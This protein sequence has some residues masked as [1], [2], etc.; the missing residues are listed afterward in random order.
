MVVLERAFDR[1][2]VLA[3]ASGTPSVVFLSPVDHGS[4]VP[5][6]PGVLAGAAVVLNPSVRA[7]D[8]HFRDTV[9]ALLPDN[10]LP[11][12]GLALLA[13]KQEGGRWSSFGDVLEAEPSGSETF[14]A[15]YEA[16]FYLGGSFDERIVPVDDVVVVPRGSRIR[17][18]Q[19][20]SKLVFDLAGAGRWDTV[21]RAFGAS[22]AVSETSEMS[23]EWTQPGAPWQLRGQASPGLVDGLGVQVGFATAR[24]GR[25]PGGSQWKTARV[26]DA[27]RLGGRK[28]TWS[29]TLRTTFLH[30]VSAAFLKLEDAV[31]VHLTSSRGQALWAL[32]KEGENSGRLAWLRRSRSTPGTVPQHS[33]RSLVGGLVGTF[34]LGVSDGLTQSLSR[35]PDV[36]LGANAIEALVPP[37]EQPLVVTFTPGA[38]GIVESQ[39]VRGL[40]A[41]G[42]WQVT[43]Y[44]ELV[45]GGTYRTG[46]EQSAEY[47]PS[48][49]GVS[50]AGPQP[51]VPREAIEHAIA[52]PMPFVPTSALTQSSLSSGTHARRGSREL[53]DA[54][55]IEQVVLSRVR[56]GLGHAAQVKRRKPAT[57]DPSLTS[58]G[59]LGK[60]EA[61]EGR[62]SSID[63]AE[64]RP[65]QR[66]ALAG[67]E[68]DARLAA[69]FESNELFLVARVT[70]GSEAGPS[71]PAIRNRLA[72]GG[73]TFG[74]EG[75]LIA[76]GDRG[77]KDYWLIV[78]SSP[79]PLR[80]LIDDTAE[81][82]M[83]AHEGARRDLNRLLD[84]QGSKR[85]PDRFLSG[86]WSGALVLDY[87]LGDVSAAEQFPPELKA[88]VGGFRNPSDLRVPYI[89]FDIPRVATSGGGLAI[90]SPAVWAHINYEDPKGDP[91]KKTDDIYGFVVTKFA[92]TI[93][94]S[95][96]TKFDG[97][98]KIG[99][100]RIFGERV[101]GRAD[102]EEGDS[103]TVEL[104]GSVQ[105]RDKGTTY[106]FAYEGSHEFEYA[107][108]SIAATAT[109]QRV[110]FSTVTS[111]TGSSEAEFQL[112][113]G[114]TVE[115]G[116][117]D[118]DWE[119][120]LG[121]FSLDY[122]GLP[123]RFDLSG[124]GTRLRYDLGRFDL[125]VGDLRF[126][127]WL[128]KS[129]PLKLRGFLAGRNVEEWGGHE[130]VSGADGASFGLEFGLDLGGLGALVP[131]FSLPRADLLL[132]WVPGA[133]GAPS[134][135]LRFAGTAPRRLSFS[136]MGALEFR[137][138][139]FGLGKATWID[140]ADKKEAMALQL[141]DWF[142]KVFTLKFPPEGATA[143][144]YIFYPPSNDLDGVGWFLS[145]AAADQEDADDQG[146]GFALRRFVAGQRLRLGDGQF[147]HADDIV[148][149]IQDVEFDDIASGEGALV[150][151][152]DAG[153]LLG[154]AA[155]FAGVVDI[156]LAL[157]DSSSLYAVRL[158]LKD[159]FGIS[160]RY[161]RVD[162][163]TGMFAAEIGLDKLGTL[164][165]GPVQFSLP[166]FGLQVYTNGDYL[167][168]V[169]Y[170]W[171]NDYSRSLTAWVFPFVGS[172][173]LY[174]A[175]LSSRTAGR[176]LPPG[177]KYDMVLRAGF[178]ARVGLGAS[179]N[180]GIFR[181]EV[182]L[183]VFGA[184]DGLWARAKDG[185]DHF[186]VRGR[187]GI[188]LIVLGRVSFPLVRIEAGVRATFWVD[189]TFETDE[190]T[191]LEVAGR[192]T[193]HASVR[194]KAGFIKFTI[195]FSASFEY[196]KRFRLRAGGR[197]AFLA[198]SHQESPPVFRF[199]AYEHWDS[200][201][202]LTFAPVIAP[203]W[204]SSENGVEEDLSHCMLVREAE[205]EEVARL[206]TYFGFAAA[207]RGQGSDVDGGNSVGDFEFV[208]GGDEDQARDRWLEALG[209]ALDDLR[210]ATFDAHAAANLKGTLEVPSDTD[211]EWSG[212]PW[213]PGLVVNDGTGVLRWDP[214]TEGATLTS[215][216]LKALRDVFDALFD[217]GGD[218]PSFLATE[219]SV[220]GVEMVFEDWWSALVHE[221]ATAVWNEVT[222]RWRAAK[223]DNPNEEP[224]PVR[225]ST[226]LAHDRGGSS[227]VSLA[228]IV[229][230]ASAVA[231]S[232]MHIP[233][234]EERPE[235]PAGGIARALAGT[236][237]NRY[238][239]PEKINVLVDRR[240]G[241]LGWVSGANVEVE[242]EARS[243]DPA[244]PPTMPAPKRLAPAEQR[245]E[246][247]ELAN[248]IEELGT[249]AARVVPSGARKFLRAR[250]VG[251]AN[252]HV[253]RRYG[254]GTSR[255]LVKL[256]QFEQ[257]SILTFR[258]DGFRSG[259]GVV[260]LAGVDAETRVLSTLF[261]SSGALPAGIVVGA[262]A[263][264]D[265]ADEK[266]EV[267]HLASG[268]A[269]AFGGEPSLGTPRGLFL[270]EAHTAPVRPS[271]D[272]ELAA[273]LRVA[274]WAEGDSSERFFV[275][276][277]PQ[278]SSFSSGK[279]GVAESIL[280]VAIRLQ[281]SAAIWPVTTH[282]VPTG[283]ESE[284]D[285]E[286]VLGG[287]DRWVDMG[288]PD[289]ARFQWEEPK[290]ESEAGADL[291]SDQELDA[292][293]SLRDVEVWQG[294]GRILPREWTLPLR[295]IT[296]SAPGVDGELPP[297]PE[298]DNDRY[299][300]DIPVAR[301]EGWTG[302]NR[303]ASVGT[304]FT[305]KIGRRD[306][307]G[308]LLPGSG[309]ADWVAGYSDRL[310][311]VREWPG[312]RL[313]YELSS[314]SGRTRWKLA[315][316]LSAEFERSAGV[317][318]RW[319]RIREQVSDKR[320]VAE[321]SVTDGTAR[322]QI[323]SRL[324]R[325]VDAVWKKLCP[326]GEDCRRRL[327]EAEVAGGTV[328]V[329]AASWHVV[330]QPIPEVETGRVVEWR[331]S[332]KVARKGG[333]Q[334]K[335][336][337]TRLGVLQQVEAV[338]LASD[339][340]SG[341]NANAADEDRSLEAF[342]ATVRR[343][344]G[345]QVSLGRSAG[346]DGT[347][348][349]LVWRGALS[350]GTEDEV[351]WSFHSMAP[352]GTAG[353]R[354]EE[355]KLE[356][357]TWPEWRGE[358]RDV[359]VD[360]LIARVLTGLDALS[361]G[362]ALDVQWRSKP[363]LL[364]DW[365]S[366]SRRLALALSTRHAAVL[367]KDRD[368]LRGAA[369][370][371]LLERFVRQRLTQRLNAFD[372]ID[373]YVVGRWSRT[374][375]DSAAPQWEVHYHTDAKPAGTRR[376][377]DARADALV[378]S[379]AVALLGGEETVVAFSVDAAEERPDRDP[380]I[381]VRF[382]P[383]VFRTAEDAPWI[384][385]VEVAP[386]SSSEDVDRRFPISRIP[387]V[388]RR[389]PPLPAL[390]EHVAV[391]PLRNSSTIALD[392][393]LTKE[394]ADTL[395]EWE[396][397]F[398]TSFTGID[399]DSLEIVVK[400][401]R[402]SSQSLATTDGDPFPVLMALEMELERDGGL[403]LDRIVYLTSTLATR[404][405]Q[406]SRAALAERTVERLCTITIK[407][408][409]NGLKTA[410]D[411]QASVDQGGIAEALSLGFRGVSQRLQRVTGARVETGTLADDR[412]KTWTFSKDELGR[413]FDDPAGMDLV[414]AITKRDVLQDLALQV[415]AHVNRNKEIRGRPIN[416][417]FHYRSAV[418]SHDSWAR[419]GLDR[420]EPAGWDGTRLVAESSGQ[421][422]RV[423]EVA[424][425]AGV[426]A[427]LSQR[428]GGMLSTL[429]HAV[430]AEV[431]RRV[432]I[433]VRLV[434]RA[435][436]GLPFLLR[437]GEVARATPVDTPL[438]MVLNGGSR[439]LPT[440]A[441]SVSRAIETGLDGSSPRNEL[442]ARLDVRIFDVADTDQSEQQAVALRV[443]NLWVPLA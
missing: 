357:D 377:G 282:I 160:I 295:P 62:L 423:G 226:I 409:Y 34:V 65:D 243:T 122:G 367:E 63:F 27:S 200:K 105:R 47:V 205:L 362:A 382:V 170:P 292:Q 340:P 164:P 38:A 437:R 73:W 290:D 390:G 39:G 183:S 381:S 258:I 135:S 266:V 322:T 442:A 314:S 86:S 320:F 179:F 108:D 24:R 3:G 68:H 288:S 61:S 193:A 159:L 154:A 240:H 121:K 369:G 9:V 264:I 11:S 252:D 206:A 184:L 130:L 173:G 131:G 235:L 254:V 411:V 46:A 7:I 150:L 117:S 139:K 18:G 348:L 185:K 418:A 49:A 422:G 408:N 438:G 97:K 304:T 361:T 87:P 128:P 405:E 414:L 57:T 158:D 326:D 353:L 209:A 16:T 441:A 372:A 323:A 376:A 280:R 101:E 133:S 45:G 43:P 161:Q 324:K 379:S 263:W 37:A 120:N 395:R 345:N 354:T 141:D 107:G 106:S 307:L 156:S 219:L 287:H 221:G 270:Q 22:V 293:Y 321:L 391:V 20:G 350:L 210:F 92:V 146:D 300:F 174:F 214:Y 93:D 229:G 276:F 272:E 230:K 89:G 332:L 52:A 152:T 6:S 325:F 60:R 366:A 115:V 186:I 402:P 301:L 56:R 225:L 191:L 44:M 267:V 260:D 217:L 319:R 195:R 336:I 339:K 31:P 124:L 389:H 194:I 262:E 4:T 424:S 269:V 233:E 396:Y 378:V 220:A 190:D 162:E 380:S 169:G 102:G 384:H 110:E 337:P 397:R 165:L 222:R 291:D 157:A 198:D 329:E 277:E 375:A 140:G 242:V 236:Q 359:D 406:A 59:W 19:H 83:G 433:E 36:L 285:I 358:A 415:H 204:R 434:R 351:D 248:S 72:I 383:H 51:L 144:T 428:I 302:K 188:Q 166:A 234:L 119:G 138:E 308:N 35:P 407:S 247:V 100:A 363:G 81:W 50:T 125:D 373:T 278:D 25:G 417:L 74:L 284:D 123:L 199:E 371:Q 298:R 167:I 71:R 147:E 281:P 334:D 69:A 259:V 365:S 331:P 67:L 75:E 215:A 91:F 14:E 392:A 255:R 425:R 168:D 412:T 309:A 443:R 203:L 251:S 134:L 347:S 328:K 431:E 246:R 429:F 132:S 109:L 1:T 245:P 273:L 149:A 2:Y 129:F 212:M 435:N 197:N 223:R 317:V 98:V 283:A 227:E 15:R 103:H 153:W 404:V 368:G 224:A 400:R 5:L 96:V 253:S 249:P 29:A 231:F 421:A 316:K 23:V 187:N 294:N 13:V 286:L 218:D 64:G 126:D 77:E 393:M 343:I 356:H 17:L 403:E 142:I 196:R 228:R 32:P 398:C 53:E 426:K 8:A 327:G 355:W 82:G 175:R 237:V 55:D 244:E 256:D 335:L 172:G 364:A 216:D 78:K 176:L 410:L 148:A 374:A 419:P 311:P 48:D 306:P 265:P 70:A 268:T 114:L 85:L 239:G 66:L 439:D 40:D 182:S 261:R 127:S 394:M 360:G 21:L 241:A 208:P 207:L 145:Y 58:Q 238:V 333:I 312:T 274:R 297:E 137:A 116:S 436:A 413:F 289:V 155:E 232:G 385:L 271:S 163:R 10:R 76:P 341:S 388:L 181:G 180:Q 54:L 430:D 136:L 90:E 211:G 41:A 305:A 416:S 113:G 346:S 427:D 171:N 80:E 30:D 84:A 111:D 88:L 26:L 370:G 95:R 202:A 387:L 99:V 143:D 177:R 279:A 432:D 250:P 257:W 192:I 313:T 303:Y 12:R 344:T 315:M 178:A 352:F 342:A 112:T 151:D 330:V 349:W 386:P 401:L 420:Q 440:L 201:H 318:E 275:S 213:L 338:P 104:T 33:Q 42:G 118:S 399:V 189:I 296:E 28:T 310:V 94:A 79:R 299:R